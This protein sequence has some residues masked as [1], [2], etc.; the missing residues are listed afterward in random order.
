VRRHGK[1]L[2]FELYQSINLFEK[3]NLFINVIHKNNKYYN[4]FFMI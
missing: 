4:S 1:S 3:F 2:L